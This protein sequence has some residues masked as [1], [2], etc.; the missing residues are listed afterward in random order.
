MTVQIDTSREAVARRQEEVTRRMSASAATGN[1]R[2]TTRREIE[3]AVEAEELAA[4]KAA[5]D[6]AEATAERARIAAVVRIGKDRGR[7]RQALRAALLAPIGAEAATGLIAALPPDS[8]AQPEA[9][10][11]PGFVAFGG[12]AAQSERRRIT[13]AFAR[14]E[15]A[16]RF[17]ATV[18]LILD[19]GAGLTGEQIAP[20]LATMPTETVSRIP[21][22]GERAAGLME[23]GG[24]LAPVSL[25]SERISEGWK[26]AAASAN[27]SIGAGSA[28]SAMHAG[29][30]MAPA[31][32]D[33]YFGMTAEGRAA[34]EAIE[35][36][37][38]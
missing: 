24:D 31:E 18:A 25:R 5:A 11:V 38:G 9:V 26:R 12:A 32:A 16:E 14:P 34:A 30:S 3:A 7:A 28:A 8:K 36:A 13:S 37:R 21:G 6:L 2:M 20:L 27:A 22:P 33:P 17:G 23:A 4:A 10:A 1:A 29:H 35:R 19:G 15:A